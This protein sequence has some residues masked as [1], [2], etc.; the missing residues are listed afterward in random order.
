M[1]RFL[2]LHRGGLLVALLFVSMASAL[3]AQSRYFVID[4]GTLGGT[5]GSGVTCCFAYAV[6]ASGQVVGATLVSGNTAF[7]A[8][9]TAA[10]SPSIPSLMISA[11]SAVSKVT[12]RTSTPPVRWSARPPS[13][14]APLC[15][16]S[17]R[18]PTVPSIPSL[19]I[20]GTLGGTSSEAFG[21][22]TSAQGGRRCC[23]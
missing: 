1:T 17:A 8:F 5:N 15:T 9:R 11:R 4:V 12:G 2:S 21:I 19:T 3:H 14:I 13:A 20:S 16:P 7:H 22:N 18:L 23:H 6:N 10:N